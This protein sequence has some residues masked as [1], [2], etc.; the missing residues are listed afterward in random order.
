MWQGASAPTVVFHLKMRYCVL[1]TL[2]A[3]VDVAGGL[4]GA[5]RA[6]ARV[7]IAR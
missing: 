6:E 4:A 7:A 3:L 2:G 5:R 1:R